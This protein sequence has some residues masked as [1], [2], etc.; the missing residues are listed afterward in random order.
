MWR[1]VSSYPG[2]WTYATNKLLPISSLQCQVLDI[3]CDHPHNSGVDS[4]LSNWVKRMQL[5]QWHDEQ[6]VPVITKGICSAL[7]NFSWTAN[8]ML[9]EKPREAELLVSVDLCFGCTLCLCQ[10]C[11]LFYPT[12]LSLPR[13]E[14]SLIYYTI[15]WHVGFD[16]CLTGGLCGSSL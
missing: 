1:A 6:Y 13:Q 14:L 11:Q 4:L 8:S 16:L 5:N 9:C 2:L 15:A 7:V 12:K 3:V 10:C